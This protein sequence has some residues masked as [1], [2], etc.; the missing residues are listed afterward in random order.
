MK[1]Y[2]VLPNGQRLTAKALASMGGVSER[3]AQAIIFIDRA[4]RVDLTRRVLDGG[5]GVMEAERIAR[6]DAKGNCTMPRPTL[7][8]ANAALRV[9]VAEL[10]AE[11]A[12]LKTGTRS[13][14]GRE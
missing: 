11:V 4:G 3:V 14:C 12:Q 9:R 10:E 2:R 1:N 6:A 5:I 7:A 8:Q 13:G